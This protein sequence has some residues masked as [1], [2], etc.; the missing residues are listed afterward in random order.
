[1][2]CSPDICIRPKV[3]TGRPPFN[4]FATP[5]IT[6]KIIDGE[7]PPRPEAQELTDSV[8]DMMVQCWDQD[9]ARRPTM[10]EV[11][12]LMRELLVSSLSIEAD[13]RDFFRA[14][15]TL[16]GNDRG[17]K[18]QVFADR[19]DEVCSTERYNIRSSHHPPRFLTIAIFTN[20]NASNIWGTCES[21]A[22]PLTFFHPRLRSR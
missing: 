13:L 22:V 1:M 6:S 20:E 9:P 2:D 8:W 18:A 10:T 16:G 5:V 11:I 15:G 7:R 21:Y 12:G 4:E 17:E 14:C 19:L 3:F